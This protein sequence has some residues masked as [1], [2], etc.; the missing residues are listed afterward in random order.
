MDKIVVGVDGS[1]H[2]ARALEWAVREGAAH[3]V[4]VTAA[5]AWG[6]LDKHEQN[7]GKGFD[8][9]HDD[10]EARLQLHEYVV[11]ALGLHGAENLHLHVACDLA[12]RTLLQAVDEHSLLVLG[13]RGLGGLKSLMLG[14]V[15]E[16]CLHSAPCPVAIVRPDTDPSGAVRRV[17][18]GV[19]P[20]GGARHA[21]R[22]AITE[23]QVHGAVLDAVHA[24]RLPFAGL[25]IYM[26][27][28]DP[29]SLDEG[30]RDM[31]QTI[32]DGEHTAGMQQPINA[33]TVCEGA[34][35]ALLEIGKGA[36]MIVVGSRGRG[37]FSGLVLGSVSHQVAHHA[38]C[39]VV[40]V[41]QV[42]QD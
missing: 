29:T 10:E 32:L 36:D 17:V 35:A 34:A 20:S 12:A 38:D 9:L 42:G 3:E 39:T 24:W 2:A 1:E 13:P 41:P 7:V 23:A 14:S 16:H 37:G 21:L 25:D 27:P 26:P 8:H 19:D 18:A 22:W 4:P 40:V 6:Y 33:I 11:D 31:L 30:A 5:L 15:T 28:L